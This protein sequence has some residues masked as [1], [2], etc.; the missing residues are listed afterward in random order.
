M[1][2]KD[3]L[4][5]CID[6]E[7]LERI[8]RWT[9]LARGEFSCLGLVD[10]DLVIRDVQLFDQVCTQASTELD[11]QALGRFLVEQDE[12]EKVRA[13]IHSHGT[14]STFWSQQDEQCI[15][16]LENESFLVS[17][18]VNKRHDLKCRVDVF[19]PVR[20]TV[21]EVPVEIRLPRLDLKAESEQQ[22]RKLLTASRIR[23]IP[24][25]PAYP[26]RVPAVMAAAA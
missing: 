11:Q 2:I 10:D 4:R 9:E 23:R 22:F 24:A 14:L 5:V 13:W 20:L 15:E 1:K 3:G 16:G 21:D 17:I 19:A 6:A 12:P 8:W 25:F 18:V 26:A 7:A